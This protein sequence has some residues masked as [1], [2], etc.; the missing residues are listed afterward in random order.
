MPGIAAERPPQ[1]RQRLVLGHAATGLVRQRNHAIDVGKIRQRI[2]AAKRILLE[3][4]GDK[5]CHMRAAIHR[6]E[7]ADIVARGDPSV[8]T[9]DAVKR[10][11]QI[12]VRGRFHVD[13][14]SIVLGKIAHAAILGV[15]ML[16]RRD[17]CG[18]ETDDLAI[19]E[20]RLA[21]RDRLDRNLVAGRDA[22]DRRH[23]VGDDHPW[24]QACARD[25][26]AV[27]GMQADDGCRGHGSLLSL[28]RVHLPR[29][30]RSARAM[31]C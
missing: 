23:A 30:L 7:D 17:R 5:A 3:D 9:T 21:R 2:V 29:T 25:Q 31:R 18:G 16:A 28:S 20:D 12:E 4:I 14:E 22:F 10:R 6:G 26:H 15:N 24:R 8:G 19:A 11:G 1:Q 27:V 13:A